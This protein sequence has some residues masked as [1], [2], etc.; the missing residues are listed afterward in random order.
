MYIFFFKF[1]RRSNL[2]VFRSTQTA[3]TWGATNLMRPAR[4]VISALSD[5]NLNLNT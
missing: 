5:L 2:Y 3:L 1:L 4:A